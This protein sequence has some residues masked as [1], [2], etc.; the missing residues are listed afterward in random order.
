M[1]KKVR[2]LAEILTDKCTGCRLCEQVCP[3]VAISM[4]L[5]TEDEIGPGKKIAVMQDDAC[6]NAQACYEICPDD[7]IVMHE[8]EEPFEV[9]VNLTTLTKSQR[10]EA[11]VLCDKAGYPPA[12]EICMC[13]TTSAE[14]IAAAIVMGADSPEAVSL[15]TGARTGC[16]ELC[17]QPVID[18]LFAAG[19]EEMPRNPKSGFQWYGRAATLRDN[20]TPRMQNL[21][22]NPPNTEWLETLRL[23]G[24]AT[25]LGESMM[26]GKHPLLSKLRNKLMPQAI[27]TDIQQSFKHYTP[28]EDMQNMLRYFYMSQ[29]DAKKNKKEE[30]K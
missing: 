11:R 16:L 14:E 27:D 25:K 28:E 29:A 15:A 10:E 5:R 20:F 9:G 26:S 19:H 17:L 23:N 30:Q 7:A 13:T 22:E 6:Y 18:F 2:M 3:T 24:V 8:L 12:L 4:R 21:V 1:P